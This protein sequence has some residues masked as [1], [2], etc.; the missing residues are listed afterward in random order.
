MADI[1]EKVQRKVDRYRWNSM[2][3]YADASSKK[4]KVIERTNK[5]ITKKMH[6]LFQ[7]DPERYGGHLVAEL[8]VSCTPIGLDADQ[9]DVW[10]STVVSIW[11][12]FL[13]LRDDGTI[14]KKMGK[15]FW[16]FR[17]NFN[18]AALQKT[19]IN[20]SLLENLVLLGKK[21]IF[22]TGIAGYSYSRLMDE[23]KKLRQ[24]KKKK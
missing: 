13:Q 2:W 8:R 15:D 23:L 16:V 24:K 20:M 21:N 10:K 9:T 4:L 22:H 1:L 7:S 18:A 3:I 12:E 14:G 6:Q 19:E 5:T 11:I 17:I